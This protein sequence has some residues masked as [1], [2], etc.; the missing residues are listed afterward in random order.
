VAEIG[1]P[2]FPQQR[3]WRCCIDDPNGKAACKVCAIIITVMVLLA[4]A[5]TGFSFIGRDYD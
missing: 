3:R 1:N 4:A 2:C 5:I